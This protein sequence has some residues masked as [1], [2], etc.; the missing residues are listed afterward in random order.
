M[1]VRDSPD[2]STGLQVGGWAPGGFDAALISAV[3]LGV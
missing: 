2:P 3:L 1:G